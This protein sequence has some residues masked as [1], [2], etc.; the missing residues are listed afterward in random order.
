MACLR[1]VVLYLS[2]Y[3]ISTNAVFICG[4]EFFIKQI[5]ACINIYFTT[6]DK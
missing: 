5:L 2:H 6:T 4:T 3:L 1:K